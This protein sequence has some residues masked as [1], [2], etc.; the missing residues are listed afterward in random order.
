MLSQLFARFTLVNCL[1]IDIHIYYIRPF[2][3]VLYLMLDF[4]VFLQLSYLSLREYFT[5]PD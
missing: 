1:L 3:F 4:K 2:K 5:S